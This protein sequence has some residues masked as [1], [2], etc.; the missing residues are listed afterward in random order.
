MLIPQG[1]LL[2]R[3]LS[4]TVSVCRLVIIHRYSLHNSPPEFSLSLSKSQKK[5]STEGKKDGHRRAKGRSGAFADET[6]EK[7]RA[8]EQSDGPG[9]T[10][11]ALLDRL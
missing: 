4:L 3:L 1:T 6:K 5:E 2:L 11:R 10:V 8:C 7:V 9:A